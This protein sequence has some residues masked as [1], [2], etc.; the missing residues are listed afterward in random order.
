MARPRARQFEALVA[1]RGPA[2]HHRVGHLG[3]KLKTERVVEL[4]RFDREVGALR[5]QFRA[6]GK[7]KSLAVPVIDMIRPVRADLER[8]GRGTDR[9]ISDLGAA[10]RMRRNP[11]A[12]LLGEH[13]RAEANAE[14]R[15]LLSE[16]DRNPVDL[17]A[18]EI[19]RIRNRRLTGRA[20]P[21]PP[22]AGSSA[23]FRWLFC[24][25]E[26]TLNGSV[27]RL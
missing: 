6:T 8:R 18:N 15:P 23:R 22:C 2:M 13:L 17:P 3:M 10:L 24:P 4:E 7:L 9:I 20:R 14:Q 27:W 19:V 21:I 16:R 25:T 11:A 26:T 5:Q 12:E 1:V